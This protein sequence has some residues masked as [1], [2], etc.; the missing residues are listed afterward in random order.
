MKIK[1]LV[2]LMEYSNKRFAIL[3]TVYLD[4]LKYKV[5]RLLSLNDC[6]RFITNESNP[7]SYMKQLYGPETN[8]QNLTR[9]NLDMAKG[10]S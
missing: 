2:S 9:E 3:S 1:Q 4:N 5:Y 8:K 6:I 7:S 10:K